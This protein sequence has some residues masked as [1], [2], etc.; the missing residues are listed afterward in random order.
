MNDFEDFLNASGDTEDQHLVKRQP[1]RQRGGSPSYR[2][3]RG[4]G[5]GRGDDLG[6]GRGAPVIEPRKSPFLPKVWESEGIPRGK[7][8]IRKMRRTRT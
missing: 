5:A 1:Q 6:F 8:Y 2:G 3:G 4:R 7:E